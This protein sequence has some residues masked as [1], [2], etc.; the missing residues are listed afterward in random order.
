MPEDQIYKEV[1]AAISHFLETQEVKDVLLPGFNELG[2]WIGW[3]LGPGCKSISNKALLAV[4][5]PEEKIVYKDKEGKKHLKT[6]LTFTEE[7]TKVFNNHDVNIDYASVA[8]H[9]KHYPSFASFEAPNLEKVGGDLQ[10]SALTT[11]RLPKLQYIARNFEV[12]KCEQL[13]APKLQTVGH[14]V[15]LECTKSLRLPS[16]KE[17]G[18]HIQFR[19]ATPIPQILPILKNLNKDRFEELCQDVKDKETSKRKGK[20]SWSPTEL[21]TKEVIKIRKIMQSKRQKALELGM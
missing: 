21:A 13:Q 16:L 8:G 11:I 18:G 3:C 19:E 14:G 15:Y 20:E 17:I 6:S 5:L 7:G 9:I 12:A 10:I 1:A 2:H 4:R